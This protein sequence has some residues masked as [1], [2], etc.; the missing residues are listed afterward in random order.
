MKAVGASAP[1]KALLCGEYAVLEGA[2]AVVSAV[3]RRVF[4]SWSD[5]TLPMPPEVATTL[6]L[7]R[8]ECGHVPGSLTLDV[9][10]LQHDQIK[11]GLGS[12]AAAAAATAAAVFASHG[13]DLDDP[14][15]KRRIFDCATRGHASV[16]PRGSGVD[17]AASSF[18]GFVR[19]VRAGNQSD[20]VSLECPSQLRIRLIWTGR[21]ARTS[22]LLA[23]LGRLRDRDSGQYEMRLAR[24]G[25][26]CS[27]FAAAFEA[28]LA[29]EVVLHA[30]SY[31]EAMRELGDAAGA[32]IVDARLQRVADLAARFSG[33]AKPSGAGGGDVAVAFF[34]DAEAATAF[35]TA[36]KG[37]GLRPIDVSWGTTGVR[38]CRREPDSAC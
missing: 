20:V 34:T 6:E 10:A 21:P 4:V 26:L 32:P 37:E 22:Q 23:E 11:L 16:A 18:G 14:V 31:G 36:C 8:R 17:V 3:D 27:A 13:H 15:S 2:P 1:G 29:Q 33:A 38:A 5:Q 25:E 28:G 19:F 9:S 35:E 30:A 7:A 24:L 12:S